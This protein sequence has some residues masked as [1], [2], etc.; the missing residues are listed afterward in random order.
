M[1]DAPTLRARLACRLLTRGSSRTTALSRT[2][3]RLRTRP[4]G[5]CRCEHR[6]LGQGAQPEAIGRCARRKGADGI[7]T[8]PPPYH[9]DRRRR[10]RAATVDRP[11]VDVLLRAAVVVVVV[12]MRASTTI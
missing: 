2:R 8:A 1:N 9:P 12:I 4:D 11:G 5:E 6:Q 3:S 7:D 10:R